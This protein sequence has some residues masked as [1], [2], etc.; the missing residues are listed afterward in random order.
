VS[1]F[2]DMLKQKCEFIT[3]RV[4]K[5]LHKLSFWRDHVCMN[6]S[7]MCI[8][9]YGRKEK[10]EEREGKMEGEREEGRESEGRERGWRYGDELIIASDAAVQ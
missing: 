5:C 1:D 9:G 3:Q 7:R 8:W 4:M 2:G 10:K 6:A